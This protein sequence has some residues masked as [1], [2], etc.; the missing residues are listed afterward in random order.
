MLSMAFFLF[1]SIICIY[2]SVCLV[3]ECPASDETVLISTPFDINNVTNVWRA[4][5]KVICFLIPASD[6]QSLRIFRAYACDGKEKTFSSPCCVWL[7]LLSSLT[8]LLHRYKCNTAHD[9]LFDTFCW[10]IVNMRDS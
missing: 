10:V 5:W 8:A 1:L 2:V 6:I 3:V 4:Q 9:E 7:F